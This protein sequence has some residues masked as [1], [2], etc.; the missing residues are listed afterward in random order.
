MGSWRGGDGSGSQNRKLQTKRPANSDIH[1]E[2]NAN[3]WKEDGPLARHVIPRCFLPLFPLSFLRSSFP[4]G[5]GWSRFCSVMIPSFLR[6]SLLCLSR[7][8]PWPGDGGVVL[9]SP[10]P[11]PSGVFPCLPCLSF[12]IISSFRPFFFG[13]E[14]WPLCCSVLFPSFLVSPSFLPASPGRGW[15]RSDNSTLD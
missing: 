9:S 11:V 14:G 13:G 4:G 8:L 5:G 10:V 3:D 15:S 12:F 7:L 6:S 2:V 1:L